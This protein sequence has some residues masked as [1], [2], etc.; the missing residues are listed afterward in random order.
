MAHRLTRANWLWQTACLLFLLSTWLFVVY[1]SDLPWWN[2]LIHV[3]L[4]GG[5]AFMIQ[6]MVRHYEL[7]D[8]LSVFPTT[9]YFLFNAF[10]PLFI[11]EPLSY[12]ASACVLAACLN[13]FECYHQNECHVKLFNAFFFLSLAGIF[14]PGIF[15]LIPLFWILFNIVNTLNFKRWTASLLGCLTVVG[16]LWALAFVF[17]KQEECIQL[18]SRSIAGFSTSIQPSVEEWIFL[19]SLILLTL[20]SVFHFFNQG[21]RSRHNS[22]RLFNTL[23]LVVGALFALMIVLFWPLRYSY[24]LIAAAFFSLSS[25]IFFNDVQNLFSKIIC[26]VSLV[27]GLCFCL[28][29]FIS[30]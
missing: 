24:L 25:G 18:F 29:L 11:Y 9:I 1:R 21:Q 2:I 30:H 10:C 7:L 20:V 4:V 6:T 22:L 8:T 17:D 28:S 26:I 19:G 5:N 3:A 14:T 23:L 12:L 13:F 16:S 27:A 15:L